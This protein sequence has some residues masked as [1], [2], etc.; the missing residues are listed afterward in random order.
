[1]IDKLRQTVAFDIYEPSVS[2]V[3]DATYFLARRGREKFVGAVG[4]RTIAGEPAGDIGG[5]PVLIGPIDHDNA[6]SIRRLL[7]WTAPRC[8]GLATSVGLGDRLGLATPGHVRAVRGTGV[9]PILAQQS[10]REMTRT[11]RTPEQVL[12]DA[13]WGVFEE[14]FRDGF[15][16]DAD[17]LKSTEDIDCTLAAGFN[18]FTIDPGEYVDNAAGSDDV[19]TLRKKLNDLPWEQLQSTA[20]DYLRA[21]RGQTFR[22][23][24]DMELTFSEEDALRA[25]VKYGRAVGH[26]ARLHRHLAASAGDR[27]FELE[28]SVDET[29]SPTTIHEHFYVAHELQRL[30]IKVVSLAPRFI[31]DFEKGIDYRGDLKAFEASYIRHTKIARHFGGYKISIHSGSDKFSIYP[32]A[33]EHSGDKV[34]VKTA[35]TSYLEALRALAEIDPA[36]V[37][38]ILGFA[39]ERYDEDKATYHVSADLRRV[40]RPEELA[41][42][43]LGGVL[44]GNDGRQLLHVTYGS[45]LTAQDAKGTS[46]FRDRLLHA[47]RSNEEVHYRILARHMRRHVGPFARVR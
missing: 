2:Q 26:T 6:R 5:V 36:L 45:V 14:G 33:A 30:G 13:S 25:A 41:D 27:P 28:M 18:L 7:P 3:G 44:D 31:G 17:H 23:G 9:T 10:I 38:E 47:L 32:I 19:P 43:E 42:A 46:R 34:H 39:F 40:K 4:D 16:S 37:R 24:L 1:M 29:D 20:E 35:G 8:V 12:D 15:G 11:Q 21:F 22:V